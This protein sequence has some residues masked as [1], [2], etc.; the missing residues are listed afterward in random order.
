MDLQLSG[1]VILITGGTQGLG[2]ATAQ[3][4]VSEGATA[5]IC[6]RDQQRLDAAMKTLSNSSGHVIGMQADVSESKDIERLL[7]SIESEIGRLDGLVSNAGQAAAIAV[8]HSSDEA[9]HADIEL[10]LMA[11]IRLARGAL[12]LLRLSTQASI[13]NVLAFAAK[14]PAAGSSPSSVTRAAGMAFT[15]VLAKELGAEGIRVNAVLPGL[16][17]SSQWRRQAE[18]ASVDVNEIYAKLLAANPVPLGRFGRA[19]E[20]ADVVTWLLSPRSSYVT[21]T[22]INVDGGLS[23][24]T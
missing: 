7:Q 5:V 16:I 20:F 19:E 4:L 12:P 3:R 6:G 18:A 11:A 15:K 10:K 14:A 2:L 9:W 21:G 1:R 23:P 17:E 8:E 13:V 22:A 24:A